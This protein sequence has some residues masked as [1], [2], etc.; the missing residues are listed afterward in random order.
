[1]EDPMSS[2]SRPVALVA[3]LLFTLHGTPSW[4]GPPNPTASDANNNTAGGTGALLNVTSGTSGGFYNTGFGT[5]ALRNTT[6]GD[7][8]TAC[9]NYALASNTTGHDNTACG[10]NALASNTTGNDNTASG[11]YALFLN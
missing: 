6:T 5:N 10:D 7:G 1:M 9:G 4:G 11:K 2:A 3:A 8:N